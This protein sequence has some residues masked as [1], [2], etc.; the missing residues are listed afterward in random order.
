[1]YFN[2]ETKI[3]LWKRPTECMSTKAI[4]WQPHFKIYWPNNSEPQH[5]VSISK[6]L[7]KIPEWSLINGLKNSLIQKSKTYFQKVYIKYSVG[8]ISQ[9]SYFCFTGSVDSFTKLVLVN[10]LYFKG[11]WMTKF[12]T[13]LTVQQPFFLGSENS[14]VNVPMMNINGK[15]LVGD[16][17]Q[18]DARILRLPYKVCIHN[19]S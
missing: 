16:L 2:R 19:I 1:M 6:L 7:L 3:S 18:L 9:I 8:F 4:S 14:Q 13:K 17:D 5:K 10:A 12:D 15:Y 11:D